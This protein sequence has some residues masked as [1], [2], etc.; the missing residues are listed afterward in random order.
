[1][2][3][4]LYDFRWRDE[5][6]CEFEASVGNQFAKKAVSIGDNISIE[7]SSNVR[8]GG[9]VFE[10]DFRKCPQDFIGKAKCDMCRAREK[11]FIFTAFDGFNRDNV[12]E[13]DLARIADEHLVYFAMFDENLI[14]IGVSKGERKSLRQIEQGSHFTLY[15]AKTPDGIVARQIETL[16]RQSG[17]R[18][19][20]KPSQKKDLFCPEINSEKGEVVLSSLIQSNLSVFD[21]YPH[22]REFLIEP[23][24]KDWSE[25]Y[26]LNNIEDSE[27][28][29]HTVSLTKDESVSG[30]VIAIKGP[31]LA[32][33][34][35]D[36][37]VSVCTKDLYGR[38]IEFDER[39]A[40]LRLNTAFQ[41]ALF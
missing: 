22:L 9:S 18:D 3:V 23:E 25:T 30:K 38:E 1:M 11:S 7:V 34:T 28:S 31:F 6:I 32:I 17:I 12:T 40:G 15:I 27:K 8:C 21:E 13:S 41:K 36:E 2:K 19:K 5:K 10:G 29:F 20:I 39:P 14:K 24:F 33:E 26:G 35:P 4:L 16:L 37:I